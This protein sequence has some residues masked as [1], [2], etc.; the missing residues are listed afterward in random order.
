[1]PNF[2]LR[3]SAPCYSV[4][5]LPSILLWPLFSYVGECTHF[6]L[7]KAQWNH[8]VH[9]LRNWSP[10]FTFAGSVP[11]LHFLGASH[12]ITDVGAISD[13]VKCRQ[14]IVNVDSS[15]KKILSKEVQEVNINESPENLSKEDKERQRREKIGLA[16]KGKVPWNKGRKHSEETRERIKQR[17]IESLKNPKVRK[18]MS[19]RPCSHSGQVKAKI[20]SA[21]RRI[22]RKRLKVKRSREKLFLSWAESIAEVAKTGGSDQEMLDWNSYDM[23]KQDLIQQ[24]LRLVTERAKE[25]EMARI[26]RAEKLA[27][28][29]AEKLEKLAHK[30]KMDEEKAR[31][32]ENK[33]ERKKKAKASRKSNGDNDE[34][35]LKQRLTKIC[36]KIS[37]NVQVSNRGATVTS[38]VPAWEKLDLELIKT[39]RLQRDVSF[40]EQIRA[41]KTKK[42]MAA[43]SH[44]SPIQ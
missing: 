13:I 23:I 30:R 29:R 14:S 17:T 26:I 44:V 5:H 40:A 18:K 10:P 34:L 43:S 7:N 42:A 39:E 37:I 8:N 12:F 15:E 9:L 27:Q 1:M 32:K 3:L 20:S 6:P 41:A 24:Q 38:H 33:K 11:R 4:N 16:N 25:N 21:L 36:Q 35:K 22:W 31:G 19:G 28:A 2:H